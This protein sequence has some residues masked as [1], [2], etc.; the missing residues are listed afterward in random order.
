MCLSELDYKLTVTFSISFWLKLL[1]DVRECI[2]RCFSYDIASDVRYKASSK[3]EWALSYDLFILPYHFSFSSCACKNCAQNILK[4]NPI[5]RPYVHSFH[6]TIL[7]KWLKDISYLT[8]L[9]ALFTCLCEASSSNRKNTGMIY[10]DGYFLYWVMILKPDDIS[11]TEPRKN[12]W[13]GFTTTT[14][15]MRTDQIKMSH[16]PSYQ[17]NKS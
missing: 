16:L 10:M 4:R 9:C 14:G 8:V 1:F 15:C 17:R 11:G 5:T 6:Y 12:G 13:K 2:L 7:E 3:S